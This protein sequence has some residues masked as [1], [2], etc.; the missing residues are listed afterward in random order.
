MRGKA[1]AWA[2]FLL[3]LL[4]LS[5]AATPYSRAADH[6]LMGARFGI[7]ILLSILVI[8]ERWKHRSDVEGQPS[9]SRPDAAE[10][11]L[12]RCRRWYYD[13]P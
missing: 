5:L 13:E 3:C 2:V 7:V 9:G 6:A 8:H 4:L 12:Q 1:A 10:S 11:F